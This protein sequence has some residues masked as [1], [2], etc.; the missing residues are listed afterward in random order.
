VEKL[1]S[2]IGLS[3]LEYCWGEHLRKCS[4]Q[5]KKWNPDIVGKDD[6]WGFRKGRCFLWKYWGV[7][8]AK[9]CFLSD[10]SGGENGDRNETFGPSPGS[11]VYGGIS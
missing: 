1:G 4:N 10:G 9:N 2:D 11:Q 6:G 7:L 3:V 5:G 8:T